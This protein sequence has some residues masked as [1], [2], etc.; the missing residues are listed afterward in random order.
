MGALSKPAHR[1]GDILL[2]QH[3][4]TPDQLKIALTEQKKNQQQLGKILISLGFV[5]E[6]VIRDLMSESLGQTSVD[7]SKLVVDHEAIRLV[8]KHLAERYMLLPINFD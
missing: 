5:S 8:P 6:A 3:I 7:L 1:L 4:I 2:E